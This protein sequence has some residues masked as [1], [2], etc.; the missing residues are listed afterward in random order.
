MK[1]SSRYSSTSPSSLSSPLLIPQLVRPSCVCWWPGRCCRCW[2]RL[3]QNWRMCRWWS[4]TH[5]FHWALLAF[6]VAI[7]SENQISLKG[8]IHQ[9]RKDP[10]WICIFNFP[11]FFSSSFRLLTLDRNASRNQVPVDVLYWSFFTCV[12]DTI[13]GRPAV[14]KC[15][16]VR[17][18][19]KVARSAHVESTESKGVSFNSCELRHKST[20]KE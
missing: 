8:R 16:L 10:I 18:S 20:S 3:A 11:L 4:H 5:S 9:P 17:F 6:I 15:V 2:S 7:S 19:G 12:Q 13:I 1:Q 14:F